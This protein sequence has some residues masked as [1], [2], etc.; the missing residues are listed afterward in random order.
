MTEIS[1]TAEA[2]IC[3]PCTRKQGTPVTELV[4][5]MK[6]P[7]ILNGALV[8]DE[9]WGCPICLQPKFPVRKNGRKPP[10]PRRRTRPRLAVSNG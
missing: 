4:R 3:E 1:I 2:Y 8:G 7:A 9:H 5:M 6:S 10:E